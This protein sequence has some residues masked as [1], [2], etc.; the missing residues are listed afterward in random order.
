MILLN[1]FC[2]GIIN[3]LKLKNSWL[4]YWEKCRNVNLNFKPE[5]RL[6]NDQDQFQM[7]IQTCSML[8]MLWKHARTWKRWLKHKFLKLKMKMQERK[9][10]EERTPWIF[11][12]VH[13]NLSY[14]Q[15][16]KE[17]WAWL[18]T[19]SKVLQRIHPYTSKIWKN[20]TKDSWITQESHQHN[21][22]PLADLE[23]QQA[24]T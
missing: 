21:K 15:F 19:I 23:N 22:N 18:C 17:T 14:I 1:R 12:L 11:I 13:S 7:I 3:R 2:S 6:K 20:T 8:Q 16:V 4:K 24:H 5:T 9:V 10:K